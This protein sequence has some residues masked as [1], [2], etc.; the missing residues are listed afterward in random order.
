MGYAGT[1][2]WQELAVESEALRGNALGDPH[3]RPVF[4]W[5]PPSYDTH[6]ERRYPPSSS[7]RA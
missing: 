1:D 3:E 5:M 2:R 6:P 7:C 4:V